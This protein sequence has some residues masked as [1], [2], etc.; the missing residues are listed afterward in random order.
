[1]EDRHTVPTP[2][3]SNSLTRRLRHALLFLLIGAV[4]SLPR[5]GER[6]NEHQPTTSDSDYYLDM[7]HVFI[8]SSDNF[9]QDWVQAA[10]HHYNR[11]L[12]PFL[13]GN[14]AH[15]VL[16]DNF[17]AAFGVVNI[18]AAALLASLLLYVIWE[19]RP[20]WKL[21]WMPSVLFLTGFPQL[22]W[23][24]HLLT[25]TLGLA[26]AFAS[27]CYAAYLVRATGDTKQGQSIVHFAQLT[28]LFIVSTLA[29]LSRE[30]AWLAV[31]TTSWLIVTRHTHWQQ[32][33]AR[34]TSILLMLVLGVIPHSA[35]A[36]A[37]GTSG[38]SLRSSISTLLDFRYMLDF[39]V[40]T[41]VCFNL[42]WIPALMS[43]GR[44][45]REPIPPFIVG[46]TIGGILYMGAGYF[47]N[48]QEGIGYPLR[49]SYVLF[50]PVFIATAGFFEHFVPAAR[51][52]ALATGFC[53]LQ[54]GTSL[55][56]VFLDPGK[57]HYRTT[58]VFN[59]LRAF[60]GI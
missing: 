53:A 34:Y 30:T 39:A 29:F 28:L 19:Q 10:P 20:E 31:I 45:R 17:R 23:G 9:N 35:Y 13:A 60:L 2:S 12:F 5:F 46:W 4:C 18:L 27:S 44:F 54:F 16:R 42:A 8:G 1:M 32:H 59:A 6:E 40:K 55:L 26:T 37:W 47:H 24:Y 49:L 52:W 22:N 33:W 7:A 51:R 36:H 25:D 15:S 11:P 3:A 38:V 14:L 50:L 56:G 57:S 21:A 48:S 58:D 41:G 43:L